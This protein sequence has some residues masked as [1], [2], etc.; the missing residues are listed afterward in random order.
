ME[1]NRVLSQYRVSRE[2]AGVVTVQVPT[3]D[4]GTERVELTTDDLRNLLTFAETGQEPPEP[5]AERVQREG[6]EDF[7]KFL[8]SLLLTPEGKVR[9]QQGE[10]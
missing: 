5:D 1:S 8:D 2:K 3:C 9:R 4:G 10:G 7:A 6:R